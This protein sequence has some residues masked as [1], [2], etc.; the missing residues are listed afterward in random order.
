[1]PMKVRRTP[2]SSASTSESN[3]TTG[4][5]FSL[6]LLRARAI[7]L[8]LAAETARPS[9]PRW[10]MSCSICT[11]CASLY[12]GGPTKYAVDVEVLRRLGAALLKGRG[13]RV[14]QDLEDHADG[15]LVGSAGS[16]AMQ[17]ASDDG[18]CREA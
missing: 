6:R 5:A 16:L 8:G 10:I 9:T 1:M 13:E 17:A 18:G 7:A 2:W 3:I 12:S 4:M 15:L 14:V 11:S